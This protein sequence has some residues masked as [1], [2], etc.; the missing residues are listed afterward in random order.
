MSGTEDTANGAGL[1]SKDKRVISVAEP[2]NTVGSIVS[3]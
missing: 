3:M 1:S 2:E